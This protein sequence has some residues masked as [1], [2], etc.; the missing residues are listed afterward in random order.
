MKAIKK[1]LSVV[2]ACCLLLTMAVVGVMTASAAGEPLAKVAE[3]GFKGNPAVEPSDEAKAAFAEVD[4]NMGMVAAKR[5]YTGAVNWFQDAQIQAGSA[6]AEIPDDST[7]IAFYVYVDEESNTSDLQMNLT[8]SEE[9]Y[10]ASIHHS[11]KDALL[12]KGVKGQLDK[13]EVK[14]SDFKLVENNSV[15]TPEVSADAYVAQQAGVVQIQLFENTNENY[16]DTKILSYSIGDIYEIGELP[17]IGG[18]TGDDNAPTDDGEEDTTAPEVKAD[19]TFTMNVE[20][21]KSAGEEVTVTI[22]TPAGLENFDIEIQYDAEVL[23]YKGNQYDSAFMGMANET[24]PGTILLSGATANPKNPVSAGTLTTLT[25]TIND[26]VAD[27]TETTL[28]GTVSAVGVNGEN[29]VGAVE[30][31]TLVVGEVEEPTVPEVEE[32]TVPVDGGEDTTAPS[33][34]STDGGDTV[35]DEGN[36]NT[37]AAAPIGAAALAV[38]AVAAIVALKKRK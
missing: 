26:G 29:L 38:V 36:P 5:T 20:S 37:G 2:V 11:W 34:D 30:A 4:P 19:V 9:T 8:A 31:A 32:P 17:E 3:A 14:W 33:Q 21:G 23:K 24:E 12:G 7:G 25:F 22:P 16:S 35:V 6:F 28:T 1:I 18:N 15:V 27:G 10:Q 13:I